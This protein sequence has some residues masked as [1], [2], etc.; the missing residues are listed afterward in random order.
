MET[1]SAARYITCYIQYPKRV[2]NIIIV[3]KVA[4]TGLWQV[5]ATDFKNAKTCFLAI[6]EHLP[7][8]KLGFSLIKESSS[9]TL[10]K[11]RATML[12]LCPFR[13]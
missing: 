8:C 10:D 5:W 2:K 13:N 6:N 9:V 11:I 12:I 1:G 7:S 4:P 3:H